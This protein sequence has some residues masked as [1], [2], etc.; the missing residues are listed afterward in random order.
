MEGQL[1]KLAPGY[2]ADL[3]VLDEDIFT[4]EP[5]KIWEIRP[6][7]TMISGEWVYLNPRLS[8]IIS[9]DE[10]PLL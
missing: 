10:H 7:G 3:L 6:L 4:C 9:S 1:G 2:F 8:E 5:D